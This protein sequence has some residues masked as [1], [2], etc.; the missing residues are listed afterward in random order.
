VRWRGGSK[1]PCRIPLTSG[2]KCLWG[3]ML[4]RRP[5]VSS[6]VELRLAGTFGV[7]WA[8]SLAREHGLPHVRRQARTAPD[9]LR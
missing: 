7:I 9:S 2:K 1:Q 5:A 6:R 3:G 8:E 4:P